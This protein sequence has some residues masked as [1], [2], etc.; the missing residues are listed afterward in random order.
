[1]RKRRGQVIDGVV[2]INKPADWSSNQVLQRVKRV[3][4][5]QKA[6]HTGTL[7]PFA[8]GLLICCLGKGTKLAGQML[9][10]DKQYVATLK[11]G[12]ETDSGDLTG[13]ITVDLGDQFVAP[14]EQQ[15][16]D[17][18]R[19][20][21][22]A[23][24]QVPPMTSALKHKGRPLYEYAR[25]GVEIE[26]A[27]REV[28]IHQ[29]DLLESD[30]L[31]AKIVVDCS[32]G[33]YVRTLAQDIGRALG[34]RAHLVALERTRIGPFRLDGAWTLAALESLDAATDA[35][36]SLEQLP[37]AFQVTKSVAQCPARTEG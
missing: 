33:T 26:R 15:I 22:G 23:I 27:A 17:I 24:K 34:V 32:K 19:N 21:L 8:T 28:T 37:P 31:T 9:D 7:D 16:R 29:L 13:E 20:F 11:F 14:T 2:L 5:A 30:G 36:V 6:G 1:M 25:Q 4:D 10:A 35:V 3:I 18:L 12:Q